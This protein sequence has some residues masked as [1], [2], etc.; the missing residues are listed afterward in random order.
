[1]SGTTEDPNR[2]FWYGVWCV[3]MTVGALPLAGFH[4]KPVLPFLP[5]LVIHEFA[6]FFFFGHTF[7]SNVWSMF[8]RTTQPIAFGI[9]ARQFLRKLAL[10][11]TGPMAVVVP[12]AGAMLTEQLGGFRNNPWAWD[13][14]FAFWVMSGISIVPD[15][16]RYGRNR[17]ADSP[18]HGLLNGGIRAM[19]A[20]VLVF[21]IMWTMATKQSLIAGHL[22]TPV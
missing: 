19:I 13:A 17:H 22:F 8:I 7:F 1:M 3:V 20:T 5:L 14:Y 10:I 18:T 9:W 11:V 21:F 15:V 16:I 6:A 12:L 2:F 4:V